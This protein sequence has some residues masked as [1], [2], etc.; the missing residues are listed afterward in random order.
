V[1][2]NGDL[3]ADVRAAT[4]LIDPADP[5]SLQREGL[6]RPA[7][8][9]SR[10][11]EESRDPAVKRLLAQIACASLLQFALLVA[12]PSTGHAAQSIDEPCC[13]TFSGYYAPYGANYA[14][15]AAQYYGTVSPYPIGYYPYPAYGYSATN[16]PYQLGYPYASRYAYYQP[17]VAVGYY[18][19]PYAYPYAVGYSPYLTG[20][21]PAYMTGYYPTWGPSGFWG[22]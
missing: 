7:R 17:A 20:Y 18:P 15:Y 8:K 16:F 2:L 6:E 12:A 14:P 10:N 21:Y 9:A 5:T 19:N 13:P 1:S 4:N 22:F 11:P 3:D